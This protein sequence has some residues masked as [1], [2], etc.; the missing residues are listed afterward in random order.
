MQNWE[1]CEAELT[2]RSYRIWDYDLS[3]M[4]R[5][6]QAE[7]KRLLKDSEPDHVCS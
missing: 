5:D 7:Y 6:A 1:K 3:A 4:L 2:W